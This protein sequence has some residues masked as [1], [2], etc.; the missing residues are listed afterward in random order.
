MKWGGQWNVMTTSIGYSSSGHIGVH[1][2]AP[3]GQ[4]GDTLE[5]WWPG[6]KKQ[7]VSGV[8]PGQV[9]VVREAP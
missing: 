3:K 6:G 1:F 9:L 5:I 4:G 8:K 7:V 2:G